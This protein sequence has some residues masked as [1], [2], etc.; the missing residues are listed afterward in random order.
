[1]AEQTEKPTGSVTRTGP[2]SYRIEL[3]ESHMCG[4]S[5]YNPM[6]GDHCPACDESRELMAAFKAEEVRRG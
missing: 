2:N 1:M 6:L 5:G 3:T 4:L